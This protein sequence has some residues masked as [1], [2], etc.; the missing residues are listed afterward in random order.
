LFLQLRLHLL[1]AGLH[2][3]RLLEDLRKISHCAS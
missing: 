1:H 3:L 2:L